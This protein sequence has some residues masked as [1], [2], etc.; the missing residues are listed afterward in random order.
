MKQ[1]SQVRS[2]VTALCVRKVKV[3]VGKMLRTKFSDG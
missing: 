3:R 2:Y 1:A